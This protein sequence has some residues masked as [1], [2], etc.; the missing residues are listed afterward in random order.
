MRETAMSDN[1]AKIKVMHLVGTLAL[2]GIERLV[3]DMCR[4]LANKGRYDLSVCCALER[5]GP[6][7]EDI[8]KLGVPVHECSIRKR[9]LVGFTRDFKHLLNTVRPDILHSQVNWSVLWQIMAAKRAHVPSIMMTQQNTFAPNALQR[10]RQRAY[11]IVC[12]PYIDIR[13]AV[14]DSVAANMAS[15]L[16]RRRKDILVIPNGVDLS[17]F[18]DG[19]IQSAEAKRLIGFGKTRI[20][21]TVG[22][23]SRQKG[24]KYLVE[25]ARLVIDAGIDCRF[26]V[27]GNGSLREP[28]EEQVKGLGLTDNFVFLG[29]RRDI[30]R[31]LRAMD[32]FVLSS[33]WEGLPIA[34][35]EAMAAG[36]PCIG[37]KV[38]G[39]T[40][41]LDEGSAGILV[42][43]KASRALAD[44]LVQVL[45]D[46]ELAERLRAAV[47]ER[48]KDF[49]IES[50]V[51]RYEELYQRL[52]SKNGR[53]PAKKAHIALHTPGKRQPPR[54][55]VS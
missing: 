27:V 32:V 11:E 23:L 46:D 16:W 49:S 28:L 22:S 5:A 24:H 15:N 53:Y 54:E 4:V 33:L 10:A 47:K 55:S 37:T 35:V 30:P 17:V 21:G 9:G 51:A 8:L 39:I 29:A 40:E 7:L 42:P 19:K 41:V 38:S 43:P 6:F 31:V 50:C 48:A 34:L 3:T 2:G 12:R 45:S 14:S 18:N 25:A 13:T 20:V 44:A 36:L 26:V 1:T 52:L